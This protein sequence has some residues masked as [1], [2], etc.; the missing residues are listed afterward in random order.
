MMIIKDLLV[1]VRLNADNKKAIQNIERV[2]RKNKRVE[3][4]DFGRF[5]RILSIVASAKLFI[6]KATRK[7]TVRIFYKT[8]LTSSS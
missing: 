5:I 2:V 3:S 1:V 7:Q 4:R 6:N 8:S